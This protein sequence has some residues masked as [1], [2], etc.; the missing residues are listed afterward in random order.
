MLLFVLATDLLTLLKN[1]QE[2][3]HSPSIFSNVAGSSLL[4]L[5]SVVEFFLEYSKNLIVPSKGHF[6]VTLFRVG[7]LSEIT[8]SW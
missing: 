5:L 1:L 4:K 2:I 6:L 3:T 7:F 8:L